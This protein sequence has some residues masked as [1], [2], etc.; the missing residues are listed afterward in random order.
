MGEVL[1]ASII[2]TR[3][4]LHSQSLLS[5]SSQPTIISPSSW[6]N[7]T[8]SFWLAPGNGFVLVERPN[9]GPGSATPPTARSSSR[10]MM[11]NQHQFLTLTRHPPVLTT[12]LSITLYRR[13]VNTIQSQR[14]FLPLTKL[15][16]PTIMASLM[17]PVSSHHEE[18]RLSANLPRFH[19]RPCH[20]KNF[21][22]GRNLSVSSSIKPSM[23]GEF[24]TT[25]LSWA[26]GCGDAVGE[27][28]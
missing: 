12:K 11:K 14:S 6:Q 20:L 16:A 2:C 15:S 21:K 27:K 25:V 19:F 23:S 28:A 18:S 3:P 17:A 9:D 13:A 24:R 7:L 10:T 8:I 4:L 22:V 5:P 26:G 1:G